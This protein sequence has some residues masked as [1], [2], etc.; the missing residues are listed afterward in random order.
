MRYFWLAGLFAFISFFSMAAY[1]EHA[2]TN[3]ISKRALQE[4]RKNPWRL[5]LEREGYID[6]SLPRPYRYAIPITDLGSKDAKLMFTYTPRTPDSAC[7]RCFLLFTKIRL[8]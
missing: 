4:L 3:S 5:K 1:A 2:D 7:S 8:D 6:R